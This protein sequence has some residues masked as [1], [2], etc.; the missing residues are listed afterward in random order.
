MRIFSAWAIGA[1]ALLAL[2]TGQAN[3]SIIG[4]EGGPAAPGPSLGSFTMTPFPD[5]PRD[6]PDA[7]DAP[8]DVTSVDSPLGG[9]VSFSIPLSHREVGS[10]WGTW[11]HGYTGDVYS[12]DGE[13][14]VTLTLPTGTGAFYFYAEPN[15][16]SVFDITATA[17]TGKSMTQPVNGNSGA[18]YFGF[19][20]TAGSLLSS[21]TISTISSSDGFAIGEFGIARATVV[22]E[23]T[24]VPE[25]GTLA[26]LGAGLVGLAVLR[27]RKAA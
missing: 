22:P 2:A 6:V 24:S 17:A 7:P 20:T 19:Y 4:V 9:A 23:P 21:I 8:L 5:D 16:L 13:L 26:L 10:G 14:S 18:A 3:A 11:S 1:A 12:T 25:P 15:Y 27:R